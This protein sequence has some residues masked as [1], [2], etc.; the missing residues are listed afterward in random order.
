[1]IPCRSYFLCVCS[2]FETWL[3]EGAILT[4]GGQVC[5]PMQVLFPVFVNLV[6]RG[7]H[8][9]DGRDAQAGHRHGQQAGERH[10]QKSHHVHPRLP[11]RE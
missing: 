1:M 4:M 10:E 7:C 5:D 11:E 2:G 8:I 3:R 9:D 6:E